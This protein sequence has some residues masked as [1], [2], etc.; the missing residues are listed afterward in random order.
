[1]FDRVIDRAINRRG[2]DLPAQPP[3]FLTFPV[4]EWTGWKRSL[5]SGLGDP[6]PTA[7]ELMTPLKPLVWVDRWG[8]Q[9]GN[10]HFSDIS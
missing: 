7:T 5:G 1:M 6:T 3:Q 2:G 4:V 8:L 9:S 10:L